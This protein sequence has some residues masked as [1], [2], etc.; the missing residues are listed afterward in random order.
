MFNYDCFSFYSSSF[1]EVM[2]IGC[3]LFHLLRNSHLF[4]AIFSYLQ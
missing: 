2:R 3:F 4:I 1:F